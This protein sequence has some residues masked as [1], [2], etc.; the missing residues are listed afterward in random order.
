M[1]LAWDRFSFRRRQRY[2]QESK[3]KKGIPRRVAERF[4]DG[5][6]PFLRRLCE[7]GGGKKEEEQGEDEEVEEGEGGRRK[8]EKGIKDVKLKSGALTY[9]RKT[10]TMKRGSEGAER[11]SR[12]KEH[13]ER[14]MK[15][16]GR[17]KNSPPFGQRTDV[18]KIEQ[19][20]GSIS[21]IDRFSFLF[22][23]PSLFSSSSSSSFSFSFTLSPAS[24]VPLFPSSPVLSSSR[25][26]EQV[27]EEEEERKGLE[28][29]GRLNRDK[30]NALFGTRASL[31]FTLHLFYFIFR[32][33][34][35]FGGFASRLGKYFHN[36]CLL[37]PTNQP[38]LQRN[39]LFSLFLFPL[40]FSFALR[41]PSP[42]SRSLLSSWGSGGFFLPL[43]RLEA[44]E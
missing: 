28:R 29:W 11:D 44:M 38:T 1:F 16:G 18:E 2:H 15:K 22:F 17:G 39:A 32:G 21:I 7:K 6:V 37:F 14:S 36:T 27:A 43:A 31:L 5:C 24:K 13:I 26:R 25:D 33:I 23:L 20:A 8:K 9:E 3:E 42:L 10:G 19:L 41:S 40:S 12:M 30:T 34:N 4:S 35:V